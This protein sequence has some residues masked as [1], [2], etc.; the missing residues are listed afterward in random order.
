MQ[1]EGGRRRENGGQKVETVQRQRRRYK[2]CTTKRDDSKNKEIGV[3]KLYG[4]EGVRRRE[5]GKRQR[6]PVGWARRR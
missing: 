6:E 4:S 1:G 5:I 2:I 3:Q